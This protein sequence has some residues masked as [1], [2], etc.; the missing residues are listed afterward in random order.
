M[1]PRIQDFEAFITYENV[2]HT[3]HDGSK[4]NLPSA[5]IG[6]KIESNPRDDRWIEIRTRVRMQYQ[7]F[8]IIITPG[9]RGFFVVSRFRKPFFFQFLALFNQNDMQCTFASINMKALRVRTWKPKVS[10]S[11]FVNNKGNKHMMCLSLFI[12]S[13]HPH[14]SLID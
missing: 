13:L 2:E 14:R 4:R 7:P 6:T 11:N 8:D 1:Q 10:L 12:P 5:N 9:R 3:N